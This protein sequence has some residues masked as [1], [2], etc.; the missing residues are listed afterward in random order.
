MT[1]AAPAS[2]SFFD[3]SAARLAYSLTGDRGPARIVAHGL[4]SSRAADDEGGF[5]PFGALDPAVRTLRYDARGHGES[6]GRLE[7]DDYRWSALADDLLAL[8]DLASPDA[9]VDAL[10]ASMGTA[11]ILWAASRMPQRFRRLVLVIPPTAWATRAAVADA[12]R[13]SADLLEREGLAAFTAASESLPPMPIL[14]EGGWPEPEPRISER[15]FPTVMRGAAL[16][17]LPDPEALRAIGVPTLLLPWDGDPGHPVSTA[18]RLAELLPDATLEVARTPDD[19]R[20]WP[21]RI[22]AFLG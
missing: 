19:V 4:T 12:Y 7:P 15:L 8:A 16:S 21:A 9:P 22:D 18:E 1:D 20:A 3:G 10:G 5:M 11:T 14:A 13:A 2:D 6:S 17:D